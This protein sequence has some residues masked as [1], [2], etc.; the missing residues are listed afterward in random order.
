MQKIGRYGMCLI[1]LILFLLQ[2]P[3]QAQNKKFFVITGK[4]VP[5]DP[6]TATGRI[7]IKKNDVA[8]TPIEIPKNS[9][10]RFELEFFNE[11]ELTF[12]YP[13]HYSKIILVFTEIPQEVWDRDSDFPA[14]PMI[15]QLPKKV[16]GI[17][18]PD[19]P[20]GKIYYAAEIDNF[21]KESFNL[22][23]S[24]IEQLEN[25][26]N[27]A[28]Q[29]KKEAQTVSA[30]TA[31]DQAAKQKDFDQLIKEADT[32]YEREEYQMALMKYLEAK[33]LFPDRAY[34]N[35][36]IA[37]LQD[38]IKALENTK[39]RREDLDLKYQAAIEKANGLFVQKT[40]SQARPV[41]EDALQ[42]KPGNVFTNGRIK[43]IDDLLA[44]LD[45]QKQYKP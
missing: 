15:V 26:K 12:V 11:Y 29:V 34:P 19:E 9:R 36:R 20:S 14:F 1:L 44:L 2:L 37:E 27:Q 32:H 38:L 6:G 10:F 40:Y 8:V 41:Y 30:V 24:M 22:D 31:Q 7:E 45:K 23:I 16:E 43:E 21:A 35:D 13:G 18:Y 42:Y 39:K 28:S 33:K 5:D 25:A 17:S 4:I 3:A